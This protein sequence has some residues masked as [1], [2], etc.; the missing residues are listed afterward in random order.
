MCVCVCVFRMTHTTGVT[1][2]RRE[3]KKIHGTMLSETWL[4]PVICPSASFPRLW[5]LSR[6]LGGKR[7]STCPLLLSHRVWKITRFSRALV[8]LLGGKGADVRVIWGVFQTLRMTPLT[9][10]EVAWE[11]RA[12]GDPG[13]VNIVHMPT[14]HRSDSVTAK[15]WTT[16]AESKSFCFNYTRPLSALQKFSNSM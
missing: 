15:L 2:C 13:R 7:S 1:T 10:V 3:K 16:G 14:D 5:I 4:P 11:W 12:A 6:T 9:H 8:T